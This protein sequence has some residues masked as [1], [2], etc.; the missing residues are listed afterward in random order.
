MDTSKWVMTGIGVF[1]VFILLFALA[2]SLFSDAHTLSQDSNVP[3]WLADNIT[4]FVG[5]VMLLLILGVAGLYRY[6]S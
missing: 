6:K 5:I 1:I 3:T 4:T 2:P